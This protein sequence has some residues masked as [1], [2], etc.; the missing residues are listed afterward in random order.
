MER[1]KQQPGLGAVFAMIEAWP[2][3]TAW[4]VLSIGTV[5]LLV[6]EARDVNLTTGN[7]IALIL[8]TIGVSGLCILIVTW[9]DEDELAREADSS[10]DAAPDNAPDA[11]S[12]AAQDNG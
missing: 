7:W 4:I 1:L 3:V 8:A 10:G 2:R 5:A 11:A 9:E 12:Q 6:Y